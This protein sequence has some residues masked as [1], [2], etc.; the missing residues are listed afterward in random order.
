MESLQFA[1]QG[2]SIVFNQNVV[3]VKV[4]L[5]ALL[6]RYS[7]RPL[8]LRVIVDNF[9]FDDR[10][11]VVPTAMDEL[12]LLFD[13]VLAIRVDREL[14]EINLVGPSFAAD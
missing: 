4:N 12:T 3:P 6:Q 5:A 9:E 1:L 11:I 14:R 13:L 7:V 8:V 10:V 2:L